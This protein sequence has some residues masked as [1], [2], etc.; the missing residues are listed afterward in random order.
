MTATTTYAK[1]RLEFETTVQ[2]RGRDLA[3]T[4]SV[5]FHPDHQEI[6]LPPLALATKGIEWRNVP[7]SEAT[8]QYRGNELTIKDLRLASGD[9]TL[10]VSG[11][12]APQG[13]KTTGAMAV[14]AANI[15][16]AQAR[17]AAAPEPRVQRH[18]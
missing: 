17:G 8:V 15:D 6:H 11:S 10:D 13:A 12:M 14:H 3:A 18:A 7:G 2:E 9:Q 1:Q 5:V 16:L 4:G